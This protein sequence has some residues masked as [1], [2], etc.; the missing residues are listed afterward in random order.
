[1]RKRLEDFVA[2]HRDEFDEQ[3][4]SDKVWQNLKKRNTRKQTPIIGQFT[5]PRV[6]IIALVILAGSSLWISRSFN[7]TNIGLANNSYE[8]NIFSEIN[9]IYAREL[10]QAAK[11][12]D[13]KAKALNEIKQQDPKLYNKFT[14]DLQQL[15]KYY[16]SLKQQLPDNPNR[17]QL[18]ENMI[19]NLELQSELLNQQMQFFRDSKQSK[20]SN[21]EKLNKEI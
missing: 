4:P 5:L 8:E 21:N 18:L 13:V 7:S 19:Q 10:Q 3:Q 11:D 14:K 1:M 17:E 2:I 6:A 20:K 9:P 12:V 16:D 15:N